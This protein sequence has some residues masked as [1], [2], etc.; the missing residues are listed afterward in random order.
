MIKIIA[1][2]VL[3]RIDELARCSS[4]PDALTRV[5]LSPQHRVAND[6]VAGWMGQA[7]MQTRID[8]IGNVIGRYEGERPGLPCL[9]LGSHLDT[10]R[11]AGKYDGML[12]VVAAIE[13]VDVLQ[14]SRTRLPFAVEVIGFADEEGLR[15]QSTLLGSRAVAGTF[16]TRVLDAIDAEGITMSAALRRFGLDPAH[17]AT[18]ARQ[19]DEVLAYVEL[20]IEQ[21]PVLEAARLPVGLVAAINGATRFAAAIAGTAGHAGTVPMRGRQDALA[22]AAEAV[23]A[24]ERIGRATP[25]LVC[26]V[27]RLTALPG[28]TNVIPGE[29]RFSIDLRS[30]RDADRRQAEHEV[31]EALQTICDRRG[32][33]LHME[34]THANTAT[35]C[36]PWLMEQLG[37]AIAALGYRERTLASG[38]GHDAMAMR[39]LTDVA[40]LFIP[41]KGGISHHPREAVNADDVAVGCE[42]L[43][44]FICH[45]TPLPVR[46]P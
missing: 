25:D 36:A 37:A 21:G 19:R 45:F 46:T 9:M 39:D 12:G 13:C 38:A 42:V 20:H 44:H 8:A 15:F 18:A 16:D 29:T 3:N 24:V 32:L 1:T 41:C 30:P 43:L 2:R 17:I 26:T 7:G 4:D 31:S 11:N 33:Q 27:G 6:L 14:Q 28:A 34:C 22:G 35:A 10:V 23:L 5:F 40:M